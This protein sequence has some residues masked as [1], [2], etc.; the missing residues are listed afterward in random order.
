MVTDMN[1]DVDG[2][3]D[4]LYVVGTSIIQVEGGTPKLRG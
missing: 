1:L 4:G 2:A 3:D